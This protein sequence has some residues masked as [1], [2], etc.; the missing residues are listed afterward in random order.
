MSEAMSESEHNRDRNEEEALALSALLQITGGVEDLAERGVVDDRQMGTAVRSLFRFDPADTDDA[1]GSPGELREG[2]Q[3]LTRLADS[4]LDGARVQYAL[5]ILKLAKGLRRDSRFLGALR[6]GLDPLADDWS[7]RWEG[8]DAGREALIQ[9]LADLYTATLSK[10]GP[11][12]LVSGDRDQ[13]NDPTVVARIRCLL[14]AG[15]RAAILWYQLGGSM[16]G[17]F[18]RRAQLADAAKRMLLRA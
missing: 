17:L 11:R 12:I 14:M 8:S 5:G 3:A 4:E 10:K 2:L 6:G 15:F 18:L 16:F 13:L 7:E 9:D 1:V